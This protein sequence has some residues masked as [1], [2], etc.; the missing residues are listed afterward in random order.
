M[1]AITGRAKGGRQWNGLALR[2]NYQRKSPTPSGGHPN[3]CSFGM[4]EGNKLD[5]EHIVILG[6]WNETDMGS[7]IGEIT[8]WMPLPEEPSKEESNDE[9]DKCQRQVA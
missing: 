8:H 3:G 1:D 2:I 6:R 7:V 4:Q 9:M 5:K